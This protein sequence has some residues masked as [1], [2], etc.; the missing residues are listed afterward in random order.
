MACSNNVSQ[1]EANDIRKQDKHDTSASAVHNSLQLNKGAKWKSDEATS[2]NVAAIVNVINDS[3]NMG[4]NNRAQLT[5]QLQIR[6][7][8]L[9]QQCKMKGP[10]HDALHVWLEQVLHDLKEMKAGD[11]EYEKSYGALKK[12]VESFYVFFE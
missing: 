11:H 12:D 10:D 4:P 3:S 2:K 9:V 1:G 8:T 7:D 5:K 6:I